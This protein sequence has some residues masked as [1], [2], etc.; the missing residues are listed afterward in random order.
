[1]LLVSTIVALSIVGV[2]DYLRLQDARER[3]ASMR[4][5]WM[6]NRITLDAYIEASEELA[7]AETASLWVSRRSAENHHIEHME[8]VINYY[9]GGTAEVMPEVRN[10]RVEYL[11]NN[12]R[13]HQQ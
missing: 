1:M 3:F 7:R 4:A 8:K 13:E 6:A 2:R 10:Q 11:R 5:S 12:I 9:E